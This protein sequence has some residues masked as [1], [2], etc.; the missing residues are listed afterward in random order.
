MSKLLAK[1]RPSRRASTGETGS[2][3]AEFALLALP[4]SLLLVG[5]INYCLNVFIDSAMRFEA[6]SVARFGALA[7]VSLGD[8]NERAGLV[9]AQ[10][11]QRLS[12]DCSVHFSGAYSSATFS[13]QPLSLNLLRP[14]RVI[15]DAVVPL[16]IAK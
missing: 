4:M 2:A 7:D 13:Y 12:T 11:R 16:E 15:I 8:A 6:I 14:E 1:L 5:S 10:S 9:C 3:V